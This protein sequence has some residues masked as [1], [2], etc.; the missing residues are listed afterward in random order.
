[1]R[2]QRSSAACLS[3]CLFASSCGTAAA[4]SQPTSQPAPATQNAAPSSRPVREHYQSR[5]W[6]VRGEPAPPRYVKP[7]SESGLPGTSDLNWLLL[8]LEHSTRFE[9]RDDDY[10]RN[11]LT[12]DEPFIMRSRG[13]LGVREILDPLRFGL[14]FMDAREF[15]S[16][17]PDDTN[18]ANENDILQLFAELYFEDALGASQPL[19]VQFG[20][21]TF[22][23]VDGKTFLARNRWRNTVNAFDGFRVQFGEPRSDW[24]VD[25][26]AVQPVERFQRRFDHGD[27]ERWFYGLI[28][29]WRGWSEIVTLEP[30]WLVLDEDRKDPDR[31]DREIHTM[32]LRAFGLIGDSGF[33]YDAHASFQFGDDGDRTQRAFATLAELGYTF[34]HEWKPRL[35]VSMAYAS[36]DENPND[37][38]SERYDRLFGL[39]TSWSPQDYASWQNLI[40]P[41]V[42]IEL[43]PIK[44]LKFNASYGPY[45]LA[46]DRDAW[47]P[48]GRRDPSG[49]AGNFVGHEIDARVRYEL[50]SR[51]DIEVGYAHFM[52]GN[53]AEQTGDADDSDLFY[54]QMTVRFP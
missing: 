26:F 46:S 10:N 3:A 22:D 5:A 20:R 33:D 48:T 29:A 4:Q 50:S 51:A 37:S 2:A 53:F 54:V 39:T 31:A 43:Q 35:S 42:R 40:S 41:K 18:V 44:P 24:Q 7:L 12:H 52:P 25:F 28:G 17:F 34:E 15:N 11:E 6:G 19:A 8:G 23:Y 36:G 16:Q 21:M 30:Y 27:D 1:M 38:V 9:V 13:Y 14:E 32:G 47:V 49:E 45:W